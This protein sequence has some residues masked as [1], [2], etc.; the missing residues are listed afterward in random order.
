MKWILLMISLLPSISYADLSIESV[1]FISRPNL[2]DMQASADASTVV[3][4]RAVKRNELFILHS[5]NDSNRLLISKVKRGAVL[6]LYMDRYGCL[7][8]LTMAKGNIIIENYPAKGSVSGCEDR[9]VLGSE[10]DFVVSSIDYSS[11]E[12]IAV[13]N[14]VSYAYSARNKTLKKI[15]IPK[16]CIS[17]LIRTVESG[18]I[19]VY[20]SKLFFKHES[21]DFETKILDLLV[22]S[23]QIYI[24]GA[25]GFIYRFQSGNTTK[26]FQVRHDR[27]ILIDNFFVYVD[28][29]LGYFYDG[30]VCHLIDNTIEISVSCIDKDY[31]ANVLGLMPAKDHSIESLVLVDG[32]LRFISDSYRNLLSIKMD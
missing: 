18:Y 22:V 29:V 7:S 23:G 25:D 17:P 16:S 28:G 9:E 24:L 5:D 26:L 21:I 19:C 14:D 20:G 27:F 6:E 10:G 12:I 4:F 3:G 2:Y 8:E 30:K 11:G 32:Q 15:E 13:F 31:L 1:R